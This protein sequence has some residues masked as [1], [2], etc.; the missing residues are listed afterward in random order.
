ML[1]SESNKQ[2]GATDKQKK[3]AELFESRVSVVA[4]DISLDRLGVDDET[5]NMLQLETDIIIH[6]AAQ[7]TRIFFKKSISS[8]KT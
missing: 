3:V 6:S 8:F 2:N 4:A 5:Y 7:V 1:I